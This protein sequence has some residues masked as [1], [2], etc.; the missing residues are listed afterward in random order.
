MPGAGRG[1]ARSEIPCLARTFAGANLPLGRR[2]S[3]VTTGFGAAA[4]TAL[5][6]LATYGLARFC[7]SGRLARTR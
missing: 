7:F 1:P 4:S 3:I 6:C 5:S 2:N